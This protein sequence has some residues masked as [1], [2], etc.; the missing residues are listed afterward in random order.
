MAVVGR[1]FSRG[2][3][4]AVVLVIVGGTVIFSAN[5][6]KTS[7]SIKEY[8]VLL[9]NTWNTD[10]NTT[11]TADEGSEESDDK[12]FFESLIGKTESMTKEEEATVEKIKH[13]WDDV[14]VEG[15]VAGEKDSNGGLGVNEA[16]TPEEN[17]RAKAAVKTEKTGQIEEDADVSVTE[18]GDPTTEEDTSTGKVAGSSVDKGALKNFYS[19]IFG[20]LGRHAPEG[21]S[22]K[23]YS[24]EC[25]LNNAVGSTKDDV[26]MWSILTKE[27]LSKC[28][29]VPED[30]IAMLKKNHVEFTSAISKITL[31]NNIYKGQGIIMV[32]GTK[33]S[34]LALLSV[35]TLRRFGTTLPVEVF[36]PPGDEK[37]D[38]LCGKLLP[39]LNAKCIY[40]TDLLPTD[41]ISKFDFQNYQFKSLALAT[42][43]FKDVLFLDADNFPIKNLDNIFESGA[44]ID[45]GMVLWPDF[46]RRTT[47]PAYY[48][49]SDHNVDLT[50]RVRNNRDA[51][52]PPVIYTD[53][54][55]EIKNIPMHDFKGTLPDVSTES[56]EIII[57]KERHLKTML[58]SLYY[59][60]Y[61][62][63][64]YYSIFSQGVSGEGDKETFIAAATFFDLPYYQVKKGVGIAGYQRKTGYRGVAML[65]HNFI[66]DYSRY[67]DAAAYVKDKYEIKSEEDVVAFNENYR[68]HEIYEKF[69]E[70]E[71]VK[72]ADVMFIH[73]HLPK[74]EPVALW[75][76][77]DLIEDGKHV[78]SYR[79]PEKINNYDIELENFKDLNELICQ[80]KHAFNYLTKA[81]GT[82][83]DARAGVCGYIT[84]RLQ[85]LE[86]SHDKYLQKDFS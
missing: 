84:D 17:A 65:Q 23:K 35:K 85:F 69:F 13:K 66:E 34:L 37:E 54:S 70:G 42:S 2:F 50:E 52:T 81:L 58:L 47:S 40:I 27:E 31:P 48:L 21:E 36:I 44:Y 18:E 79:S 62:P 28:L 43:S 57:D 3:K 4:L 12:S 24:P 73:S 86:D 71:G 82:N 14:L 6:D 76:E 55:V 9:Q 78:R 5:H 30:S 51:L 7:Q 41:S 64:W 60:V 59:N 33:F 61:G 46:W 32:G 74:F 56:G 49:I 38:N 15:V 10:A 26:D 16:S 19:E 63:A 53:P 80:K 20:L 77:Q 29:E 22:E 75:K 83:E 67:Q 8:S 39:E 25:Q 72:D 45:N 11:Y 68:P 1:R